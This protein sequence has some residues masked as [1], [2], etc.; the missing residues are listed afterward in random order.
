M[1]PIRITLS[2]PTPHMSSKTL[3]VITFPLTESIP[4]YN[5]QVIS[6]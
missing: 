6:N 5:V 2:K 4:L 1:Q 3:L